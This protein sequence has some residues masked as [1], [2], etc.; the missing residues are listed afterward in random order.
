M[1]VDIYCVHTKHPTPGLSGGGGVEGNMGS[2]QRIPPSRI[3][4]VR[5]LSRRTISVVQTAHTLDNIYFVS[6][7][8]T[9]I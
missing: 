2:R 3:I 8:Y 7:T 1:Y 6:I 5:L 9:N 4:T